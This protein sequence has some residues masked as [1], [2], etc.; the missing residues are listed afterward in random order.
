MS[1]SEIVKYYERQYGPF[2]HMAQSDRA[3]WLRYL[4]LGGGQYGPFSYDVRVGDGVLMPAGTSIIGYKAAYALTTKRID[5]LSV[6][7]NVHTIYEVK[8]RAGLSAVGQLIGY[9]TLYRAQIPNDQIVKVSLVTDELQPDMMPILIESE[10]TV[11]QVG[12]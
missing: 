5:V 10:I 11:I 8:K 7:D 2:I 1:D 12:Y 9:R 4:M 6:S 3:I